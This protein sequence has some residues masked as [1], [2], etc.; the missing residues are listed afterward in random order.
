MRWRL[1]LFSKATSVPGS[2]QIGYSRF[3]PRGKAAGGCIPELRGDQLVSD[4]G[5]PGRNA[6]QAVVAHGKELR[7]VQRPCNPQRC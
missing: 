2:R 6:V 4:P 5:G 3:V 1:T 7:F